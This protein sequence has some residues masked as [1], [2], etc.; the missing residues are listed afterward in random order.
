MS[1]YDDVREL[2]FG[3]R[4]W[5]PNGENSQFNDLGSR[6]PGNYV[7][8]DN[9]NL[10]E[11]Y[12]EQQKILGSLGKF[13]NIEY[14]TTSVT[15]DYDKF[16]KYNNL[17][18]KANLITS[19]N[20]LMSHSNIYNGKIEIDNNYLKNVPGFITLNDFRNEL[21]KIQNGD[22]SN[23][24]FIKNVQQYVKFLNLRNAR[25]LFNSTNIK[26]KV[27][28][29][30]QSKLLEYL[31]KTNKVYIRESTTE[32]VDNKQIF[33]DEKTNKNYKYI[34]TVGS[35][36]DKMIETYRDWHEKLPFALMAYR[37]TVR[38]YT[39]ATPYSLV[40]STNVVLPVKVEIPSLWVLMETKIEE[41]EWIRDC[42]E[43]L[44]FIKEKRLKAI[45]HGQ[46]Y[47]KRMMRA[48]EKKLRP[49]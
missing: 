45:Q 5:G 40:Y 46:M 13:F 42:Y 20:I 7:P 11:L 39:G 1:Y 31:L 29:N 24:E 33:Y 15:D 4:N 14:E 37:T 17:I 44:N 10:Q 35:F 43:Q 22:F 38:T 27:N 3:Y 6:R 2:Q 47:Q 28:K 36:F 49:R 48:H 12:Y 21:Q 23:E 9:K 16:K 30:D 32:P 19:A 8:R 26:S 34:K 18:S 25:S 41:S